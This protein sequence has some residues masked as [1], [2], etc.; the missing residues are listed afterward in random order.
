MD[1][2]YHFTGRGADPR[3]L[4]GDG[5]LSVRDGNVFA[6]PFLGPISG[7]LNGIVPGMGQDVARNASAQFHTEGGIIEVKDL[8]VEGSGFSLLG[9]GQLRYLEDAM[10][11]NVR[12]NARGLPGVVLFPVSKL[13]EY[14][15]DEKLSKPRWR[16]KALP[17]LGPGAAD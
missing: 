5:S 9:G 13:F 17:R 11:F 10:D 6:I 16:P 15:A 14:V 7:I 12:I 3:A 8:L 1:G 4:T 2:V